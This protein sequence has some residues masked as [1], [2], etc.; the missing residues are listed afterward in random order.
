[1][2][3]EAYVRFRYATAGRN[4]ARALEEGLLPTDPLYHT[5]LS[6]WNRWEAEYSGMGFRIVSLEVF[7][8]Y[9][10]GYDFDDLSKLLEQKKEEGEEVVFYS[11]KFYSELPREYIP[12][13]GSGNSIIRDY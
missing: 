7:K 5:L 8:E 9:L 10:P 1:M 13:S 2:D 11:R 6:D 12:T 3:R 4:F